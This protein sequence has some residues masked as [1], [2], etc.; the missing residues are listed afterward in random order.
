MTTNI[1]NVPNYA[2]EYEYIVAKYVDGEWWFWGA[3][4]DLD[5]AIAAA[6][7]MEDARVFTNN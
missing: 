6:N 4:N 2:S 5:E 1:N 7:S 3:W